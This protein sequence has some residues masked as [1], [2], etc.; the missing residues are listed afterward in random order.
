[1]KIKKNKKAI[2]FF[3]IAF[4]FVIMLFI[5]LFNKILDNS[6]KVVEKENKKAEIVE[7][8]KEEN[9]KEEVKTEENVKEEVKTEE[10]KKETEKKV[11]TTKKKTTVKKS[12]TN[13]SSSS[14]HYTTRL[15]SFWPSE[16][17]GENNCTASGLCKQHMTANEN[18]WYMYQGRLAIA[19]ASTRLGSSKQKT[20]KLFQKVTLE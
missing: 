18:G 14:N 8:K 6:K 11:T 7:L 19:T 1:M 10:I 12:T 2:I 3:I 13:K 4:I 9:V 20:Y 5:L 15:T 17:H 16:N